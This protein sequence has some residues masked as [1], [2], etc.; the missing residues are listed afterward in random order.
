MTSQNESHVQLLW[1]TTNIGMDDKCQLYGGQVEMST[2]LV[3]NQTQV[4][5]KGIV[6]KYS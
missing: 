1:S 3:D 2:I 4:S 6:T 5:T